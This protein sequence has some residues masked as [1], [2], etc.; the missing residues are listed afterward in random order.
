[1]DTRT[2]D[3]AW[4][5]SWRDDIGHALAPLLATFET[6]YGYPPGDNR[7]IAAGEG[8]PVGEAAIHPGL[9]LVLN[10]FY[11]TIHEVLLPDIGNGY[12]IHPLDH[13]LNELTRQGPV[14]LVESTPGVVFGSDGG[15]ILYAADHSG[16]IY[17]SRAASRNSGFEL[18]APDLS[19]FLD[20]LRQAVKRFV[21]TGQPGWL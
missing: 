2:P 9:P 12:F 10:R 14:R 15:G 8:R 4:L 11:R 21:A 6:T 5:A 16:T 13:V 7:I 17:R 19:S 3:Q 1:M 20:Q 18:V